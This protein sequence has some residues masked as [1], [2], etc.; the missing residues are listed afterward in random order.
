MV[1]NLVFSLMI[2][3][4]GAWSYGAADDSA[5]KT[6]KVKTVSSSAAAE[7][8]G[9][10]KSPEKT[11]LFF[12]NPNGRP[13]Q[14]QDEVLLGVKDSIAPH[15]A[16]RYYKTTESADH[17]AFGQYGIRGLPSLILIDKNGK[18][19][20]RFTPGIHDAGTLLKEIRK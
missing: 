9:S 3:L 13:C 1:Q 7:T 5:G 6:C 17:G 11:L 8:V 15:A 14:M 18:T 2:L 4:G 16:V 12:M 10:P 19:L 20:H